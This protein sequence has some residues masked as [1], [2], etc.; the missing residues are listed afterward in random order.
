MMTDFQG[1]PGFR[2]FYPEDFVV[3]A[4]LTRIWRDVARRYGFEEYDGPPLEELELYTRKSGEEI[5][6]QLYEFEDKGGRRVALRPEMTPTL[7]RMVGAR[8]RALRKPIRWYSIPQLFRYERKQRGRLREHFQLNMD[9][10]GVADVIADAEL[11][12]AAI[13]ICRAAGLDASQ[14]RARVSDRRVLAA[15]LGHVGVPD[16]RLEAVYG[17][18]DRL[19]RERRDRLEEK[20]AGLG[21]DA[22]AIEA[23]LETTAT[24]GI[25]ELRARY[26]DVPA[27]AETIDELD[28]YLEHVDDLG[29]AEFVDI[30]LSVVRGLA[31]YTGIVFE[32]WDARREL[33][34]V[35]GGGRYDSL[36]DL[37]GGIDMPA[38]GFGMG[39]VVL[40]EL[41]A[42]HGLLPD[43]Q[44]GI[45][46]F[47]AY[48]GPEGRRRALRV[49]QRLRRAGHSAVY[50]FRERRLGSQ[51]KSADQL[52]ARLAIILGPQEV[53]V[54]QARIRSMSSG[55]ERV[56]ALEDVVEALNEGDTKDE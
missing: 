34:A 33:R 19:D 38:L 15:I 25:E 50:D 2:D 52:G 44:T 8:A 39:D 7:A 46:C 43:R 28:R 37:V 3:R 32:L 21:L 17:V 12:A 26:G 47:V 30:D 27:V 45:D 36:L 31:Y 53:E 41:L 49:A 22:D 11:I 29:V 6:E 48:I 5:V 13:D 40:A 16:D 54:G 56:V 9:I 10:I 18:I 51:L 24:R 1:L 42:D 35:C 4:H 14:I 23:V 55:D 20:L